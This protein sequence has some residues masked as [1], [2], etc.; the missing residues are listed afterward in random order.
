MTFL[1]F[2]ALLG[3]NRFGGGE[4]PGGRVENW[5]IRLDGYMVQLFNCFNV[6]WLVGYGG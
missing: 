3:I 6:W 5:E 4:Y 2:Q 1:M